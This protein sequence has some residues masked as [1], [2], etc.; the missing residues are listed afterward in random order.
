MLLLLCFSATWKRMPFHS[1]NPW[2]LLLICLCYNLQKKMYFLFAALLKISHRT[3]L[4]T[5]VTTTLNQM[6]M[7]TA[8][9]IHLQMSFRR[10]MFCFWKL[11][12]ICF[13][14]EKGCPSKEVFQMTIWC[15]C[16]VR[17]ITSLLGMLLSFSQLAINA[18]AMKH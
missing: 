5:R 17:D 11:F 6:C 18:C 8:P 15:I 12:L 3:N 13:L 16:Y 10:I 2:H 4:Q 7:C 14:L 9:L 1:N